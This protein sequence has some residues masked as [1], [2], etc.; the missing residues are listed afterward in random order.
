M[1]AIVNLLHEVAETFHPPQCDS[2][3]EKARISHFAAGNG[4]PFFTTDSG[5]ALRAIEIKRWRS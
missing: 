1:S 4:N 3:L 5:A 2:S